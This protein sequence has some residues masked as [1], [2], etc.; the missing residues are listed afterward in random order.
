MP[1]P[2]SA[3]LVRIERDELVS[4]VTLRRPEKLNA[5]NAA[6]SE[7]FAS[8][9][10]RLEDTRVL[11]LAGEGRAFSAGG[12]LEDIDD[13]GRW[14]DN[15]SRLRTLPIPTI[16]AIEGYCFGGGMSLAA[17]CD[18][19]VA[20][21]SATFAMP[22]IRRGLLAGGGAAWTL[23][24]LVGDARAR[25]LLLGGEPIDAPTAN[26]FGFVNRVVPD[27]QALGEARAW[28]RRLLGS[29]PLV[30]AELKAIL[31][32]DVEAQIAEAMS[33]ET[34]AIDRLDGS[35]D[36]D[37]GLEA[38]AQRREPRFRGR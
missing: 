7:A 23:T 36:R 24:R 5:L 18:F 20:G 10:D 13:S 9:L 27:G 4:I 8:A 33:A 16:A 21:R 26:R 34:K 25:E 37:E 3:P 32:G 22:E 28:A 35:E 38:F 19:R 29:A 11:V 14:L 30:I 17:T 15:F 31:A 6:L 2:G 12:D 1:D